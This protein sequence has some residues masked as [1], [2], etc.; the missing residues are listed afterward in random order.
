MPFG[1]PLVVAAVGF[2]I[3]HSASVSLL[4]LTRTAPRTCCTLN[5]PV[6]G[7][8]VVARRVGS[9]RCTSLLTRGRGAAL[10]EEMAGATLVQGSAD[11]AR[12]DGR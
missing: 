2:L 4:R 10:T 11:V 12:G 6:V 7:A 9:R 3:A 8:I 5:P 1:A